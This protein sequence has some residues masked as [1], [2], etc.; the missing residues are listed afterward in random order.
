[1]TH[2]SKIIIRNLNF[3]YKDKQVIKDV[4][5]EI[6]ANEIYAL[7]GPA[8]SGTT[9]LFRAITRLSD[10][11]R[12]ARMEGE[13]LLDGKDIRSA[14]VSVTDLRRRVGMV[15]EE[16][17]TLPMSIFDNVAYGP[18]MSGIKDKEILAQKVEN[19]LRL[20]V[21]WDEV[22][23]RLHTPAL[24]LSGGQQQRLCIARIL[25]LE[26][27]VILL[28]RPCAALDPI[29]TYKIEE[30]LQRLKE[31]FTIIIIPHNVQQAGRIADR[32]GFMLMGDLIEQGPTKEMFTNPKDQRT[33]DYITG[34]FG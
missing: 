31:Q 21:L 30:S 4:N 9:T 32:S 6:H 1:M 22:K 3:F 23:D 12:G 5:M 29:S 20:T 28:D 24:R 33:S 10:L 27:D 34:R 13:I 8:N 16:P 25:A 17:I 2:Q 18:R 26:P 15:F 11:D 19:A 7:F 14:D